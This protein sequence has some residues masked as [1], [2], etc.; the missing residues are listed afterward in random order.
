MNTILINSQTNRFYSFLLKKFF[1]VLKSSNISMT[2]EDLPNKTYYFPIIYRCYYEKFY[3]K[4][5]KDSCPNGEGCLVSYQIC[6]NIKKYSINFRFHNEPVQ[7]V[8]TQTLISNQ[9]QKCGQL[10]IIIMLIQNGL[11]PKDVMPNFSLFTCS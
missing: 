2:A 6:Y 10:H 9:V 5:K 3:K 4:P 1:R 11:E 7:I 8:F